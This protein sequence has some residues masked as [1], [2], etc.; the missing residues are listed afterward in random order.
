M[1]LVFLYCRYVIRIMH[2]D[3]YAFKVKHICY[4]LL[5]GG[6]WQK[7]PQHDTGLFI[8]PHQIA[9]ASNRSNMPAFLMCINYQ[10]VNVFPNPHILLAIA[11]LINNQNCRCGRM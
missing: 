9:P 11:G 3:A 1:K 5:N 7:C 6:Y 2:N 10:C 4:A 8:G